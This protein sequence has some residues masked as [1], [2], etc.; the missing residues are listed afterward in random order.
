MQNSKRRGRSLELPHRKLFDNEQQRSLKMHFQQLAIL[1]ISSVI[2]VSSA[3]SAETLKWVGVMP[4][5]QVKRTL[6][7]FNEIYAPQGVMA[8][9]KM[10]ETLTK[11]FIKGDS[12]ADVDLIHLKDADSLTLAANNGAHMPISEQSHH[13]VA[14][15][16]KDPGAAWVGLLK[17]ARIIY[18]DSSK[19]H[20][21]E[22]S[23]YESLASPLFQNKVCLRQANSGYNQGLYSFLLDTWGELKFTQIFKAIALSTQNLPLIEKDL[24][25]VL[26]GIEKGDCLIGIANTYYFTRHLLNYP[27]TKIRPFAHQKDDLGAHVNVDGLMIPRNAKSGATSELLISFLLS[28]EAQLLLSEDTGKHPAADCL[29]NPKLESIFPDLQ[30]NFSFDLR[31]I[32]TLKDRAISLASQQGMK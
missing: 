2:S 3:F 24:D 27:D 31:K 11:G 6:A 8:E 26:V 25:G 5:S 29:L 4:E 21:S 12:L 22:I 23:G 19:V 18:Y 14:S 17:R 10:D 1:T 30:W 28:P 13:Q 20:E 32:S 9:Y 15:N 7:R 16:L